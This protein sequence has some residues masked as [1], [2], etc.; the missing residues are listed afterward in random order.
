M[1]PIVVYKTLMKR[2]LNNTKKNSSQE[3]KKRIHGTSQIS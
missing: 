3:K 1:P 2:N